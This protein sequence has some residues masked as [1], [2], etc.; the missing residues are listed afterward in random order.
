MNNK[1]NFDGAQSMGFDSLADRRHLNKD[2]TTR[3]TMP[4]KA[5]LCLEASDDDDMDDDH[6]SQDSVDRLWQA[7]LNNQNVNYVSEL[8][9]RRDETEAP[10][11]DEEEG[12]KGKE[13]HP[14]RAGT[15]KEEEELM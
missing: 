12:R 7:V 1:A 15:Q 10:D 5:G 8:E 11:K 13:E 2:P 14:L 9:S 4:K 3:R 6:G